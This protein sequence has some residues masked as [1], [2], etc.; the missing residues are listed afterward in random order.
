MTTKSSLRN[1]MR[2]SD[3]VNVDLTEAW[4]TSLTASERRA[5]NERLAAQGQEPTADAAMALHYV[6]M[7]WA[8][9][10]RHHQQQAKLVADR[11]R[12]RRCGTSALG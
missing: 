7:F 12:L 9:V 1:G 11:S 2:E 4:W 8:A 6:D 5:W 10:R 3:A